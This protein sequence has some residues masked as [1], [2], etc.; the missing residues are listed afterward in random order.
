MTSDTGFTLRLPYPPSLNNLYAT[1]QGR[2]VLSARG[3]QYHTEVAWL[4]RQTRQGA[5]PLTG[6]LGFQMEVH[7][8]DKRPCDLS[9]LVKV[10]EDAIA[11][12]G[13]YGND[14]QIDELHVL[15][16]ALARPAYILVTVWTKEESH[17]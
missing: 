16:G 13:G 10:T 7:R 14:N 15:R 17:V 8:H 3:R 4:V 9:N 11:E 2:R 1:V 6:R 5:P 12:G